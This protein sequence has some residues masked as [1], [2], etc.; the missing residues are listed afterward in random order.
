MKFANE[1]TLTQATKRS[2]CVLQAPHKT[3]QSIGH[4]FVTLMWARNTWNPT[5]PFSGQH[6]TRGQF[7]TKQGHAFRV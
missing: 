7:F 4:T 2:N 1:H 6:A 5:R 3:C